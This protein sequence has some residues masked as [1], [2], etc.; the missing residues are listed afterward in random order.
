MVD[1]DEPPRPEDESARL[2]DE[3]PPEE[4]ESL[5]EEEGPL[6]RRRETQ[7]KKAK[8]R[9]RRNA[10]ANVLGFLGEILITAGVFVAL[11]LVWQ[12]WWTD[13]EGNAEQERIVAELAWEEPP[14]AVSAMGEALDKPVLQPAIGDP[15]VEPEPELRETF[16]VMYIPRFGPDY[17]RPISEGTDRPTVLDPLGIGHYVDT[18]MPG[19]LGNF[20]VAGHRTTYG[21]PFNQIADLQVGDALIVRTD[22]VWYVYQ[23]T[24]YLI[25]DPHQMEVI[26]PVPGHEGRSADGF[27]I[28]LTSCHPM[29][30]AAERY[31][32]HGELAY[33]GLVGMGVPAELLEQPEEVP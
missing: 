23:V 7:R 33:W 28:T 30:S 32:V 5:S 24:E 11:F 21:K 12:L 13:I 22:M 3:S 27:Y 1:E 16:A 6:Q 29:F 9:T 31:I 15:P 2:E 25:V 8:T 20:S 4:D 10:L 17:I 19:E 18:A 26:A 14:V